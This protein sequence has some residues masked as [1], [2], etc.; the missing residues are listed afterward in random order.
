MPT[1]RL[2]TQVRSAVRQILSR[3]DFVLLLLVIFL[4][5]HFFWPGATEYNYTRTVFMLVAAPALALVH[6]TALLRRD[7]GRLLFPWLA[8]PLLAL[9]LIALA[10]LTA[11]TSS[12]STLQSVA[13]LSA[14]LL[15]GL[16]VLNLVRDRRDVT[17]MIAT[18]S[19]SATIVAA[20]AVLQY[21]GALPGAGAPGSS[22]M[23]TTMGNPD[24]VAGFLGCALFPMTLLVDRARPVV[25]RCLVVSAIALCATAIFLTGQTA[26]LLGIVAGL[27]VIALGSIMFPSRERSRTRLPAARVLLAVLGV[28][29]AVGAAI[30]VLGLLRVTPSTGADS[31]GSVVTRAWDA[32][33]GTARSMFW[34]VGWTMFRDN[35]VLGVGL[36]NY[37]IAYPRYEAIA[38]AA[39]DTAAPRAYVPDAA[40]AHNDFLQGAAELGGLGALAIVG[41]VAV[42]VASIWLRLRASTVERFDILVLAGGVTVFIVHAVFGFPTHLAASAFS[43]LLITAIVLSPACGDRALIAVS[44]KRSI[45]VA[46]LAISA[47]AA[48]AALIAGGR[49]LA[50]NV[51]ELRGTRHVQVGDNTEA[52]R[53]LER[54]IALDFRPRQSYFYLASA[55]YRLGLYQ[56]ALA[57]LETCLT[58]LPDEHA[59]LL[60][61]DLAAGLGRL[62]RGLEVI[63]FLLLTNPSPGRGPRRSTS[64]P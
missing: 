56:E 50:A 31:T 22:N 53:A 44:L 49:D 41:V 26:V 37:K 34:Q 42:F 40:Q 62:D 38:L 17:V 48:I 59:Q 25:L 14:F 29:I 64:E 61:A 11:A 35:P 10:S 4:L 57:S 24:A 18:L 45:L 36:G 46:L 28:A 27:C 5:P 12:R 30:H 39:Q 6:I 16:L 43:A 55:Q 13:V 23:I 60:Y 9:V 2:A 32:N 63:D 3:Y 19:A 21:L 33:S 47:A 58:V 20:H 51:L 7:E 8:F 1:G 15:F 52:L 54:S